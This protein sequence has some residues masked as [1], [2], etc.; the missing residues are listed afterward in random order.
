MRNFIFALLLAFSVQAIEVGPNHE[1]FWT[2]VDSKTAGYIFVIAQAGIE[3]ERFQVDDPLVRSIKLEKLLANLPD[4]T[5]EVM[6]YTY[7]KN[8]V[9]SRP[10]NILSLTWT[11]DGPEPI[12][13]DVQLPAQ[14]IINVVK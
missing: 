11:K 3:K 14:V 10:S 4:G 13:I 5:Y 12:V 8:L 6:A 7:N 2:T 1:I 9:M